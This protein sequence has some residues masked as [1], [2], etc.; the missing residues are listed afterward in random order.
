MKQALHWK[1]NF[2]DDYDV[3][4]LQQKVGHISNIVDWYILLNTYSMRKLKVSK[5]FKT[6]AVAQNGKKHKMRAI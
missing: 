6:L 4:S 1:L 3:T 5:Y 2:Y